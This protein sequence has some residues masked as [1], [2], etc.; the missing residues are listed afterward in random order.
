L[1]DFLFPYN[2]SQPI[3]LLQVVLLGLY[4][5]QKLESNYEVL[6]RVTP[7]KVRDIVFNLSLS[8]LKNRVKVK[9]LEESIFFRYSLNC[10]KALDF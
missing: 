7:G 5:G 3:G 9:L 6:V 8:P 2:E 10:W 1:K 4:K